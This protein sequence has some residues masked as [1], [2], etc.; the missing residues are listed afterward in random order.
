MHRKVRA[1]SEQSGMAGAFLVAILVVGAL[2]SPSMG[3]PTRIQ[4][5]QD[6]RMES[7]FTLDFGQDGIASA[8]IS[9]TTFN[10]EIDGINGTAKFTYYDQTIDSLTLPGGLT[11]GA[12]R[13]QI[14]PDSSV[15]SYNRATGEFTTD[16]L[17][18][19]EFDGDLHEINLYS[20]IVLQN[21][22]AGSLDLES[23]TVGRVTMNWAGEIPAPF[24]ISY[25]CTLFASS[26]S[27]ASSYIETEMMPMLLNASMPT[28][29]KN[30]LTSYLNTAISAS[31]GGN[32]RGAISALRAFVFKLRNSAGSVAQSDAIALVG[33]ANQ[34]IVLAENRRDQVFMQMPQESPDVDA[35]PVDGAPKNNTTRDPN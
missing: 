24:D 4:A 34:A 32:V 21:H 33:A 10:L 6:Q 31:N 23:A 1:I 28:I 11:T 7:S 35:N 29:L 19:M 18:S 8:L 14:V 12:I 30:T 16:E 5:R 17:Y 27:T 2:A 3:A 26:Q 9:Q 20:P 25:I 13:V 22:S 15:G